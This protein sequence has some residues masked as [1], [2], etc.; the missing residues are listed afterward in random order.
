MENRLNRLFEANSEESRAKAAA[1]WK[2]Q[3]KIIIGT[4]D[5][6]TPEEVIYAAGMLPWRVTGTWRENVAL[7]HAYRS[8]DT[9][10]YCNH[11]L[12]SHLAGEFDFLNGIVIGC[13][14]DDLRRLWDAWSYIGKTPFTHLLYTP[15]KDEPETRLAYIE[16]VTALKTKLEQFGSVKITTESLEN[17]IRVYNQWRSLLMKVYE[18]RKRE[19]PPI[20]GTE[21]L[22]L[23][24]ASFVM[25]KDVFNQELEALLP[26]LEQRTASLKSVRPRLL[27]SGDKLDN[28]AYLE[29]IEDA[30]GLVAMDDLDTG[31]RYFWQTT[32]TDQE[33]LTALAERYMSRPPCPHIVD[34]AR[35]AGSVIG[36][37]KEYNITGVLNLPHMYG[38]VRQ[39]V[40]PYFRDSLTAA[41]IPN[42]SFNIEYHLANT[43]QLRTRIGAFIEM[44][45]AGA[46]A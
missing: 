4:T 32:R 19:V 31:S 14:D 15:H 37:A 39:M 22:K 44:L 8:V 27:V 11:L 3:G 5:A 29:L 16:A 1:E 36:W 18:L 21:A 38:Y 9:D 45:S 6:N 30:G 13:E 12:Q 42:M 24:T 33:P 28:P 23:V 40:T 25:P 20:S 35:Y 26:Y 46:K 43:G 34:W 10:V 2:K 17:A 7:A 41:G